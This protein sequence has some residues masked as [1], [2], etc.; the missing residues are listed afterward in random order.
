M[1]L[2]DPISGISEHNYNYD[3]KKHFKSVVK[4]FKECTKM[5][6]TPE[7]HQ[8]QQGPQSRG[9]GHVPPS[10]FKILKN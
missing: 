10:I 5:Q 7:L 6:N 3:K 4:F 8:D 1:L 9:A 2:F